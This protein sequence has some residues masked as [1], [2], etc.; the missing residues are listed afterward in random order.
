MPKIQNPPTKRGGCSKKP[1]ILYKDYLIRLPDL[2]DRDNSNKFKKIYII[3]EIKSMFFI[4]SL[5]SV[6]YLVYDIFY[7]SVVMSKNQKY[8]NKIIYI[9]KIIF[10]KLVDWSDNSV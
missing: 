3:F 2:I 7:T 5:L 4:Y 10:F 9:C 1:R 8:N 6:L